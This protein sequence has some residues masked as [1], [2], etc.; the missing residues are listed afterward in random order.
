MKR[1]PVLTS[2]RALGWDCHDATSSLASQPCPISTY[3][4]PSP[5]H[6]PLFGTKLNSLTRTHAIWSSCC[7]PWLSPG[8]DLQGTLRATSTSTLHRHWCLSWLSSQHPGK[9]PLNPVRQQPQHRQG[10]SLGSPAFGLGWKSAIVTVFLFR[11]PW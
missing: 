4:L 5:C 1:G 3:Q 8:K 7:T 9:F 2:L 10:W 11:I 6:C